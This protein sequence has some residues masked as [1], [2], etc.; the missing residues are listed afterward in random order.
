M[1]RGGRHDLVRSPEAEA[2]EHDVAALGRARREGDLERVGGDD[3]GEPCAKSIPQPHHLLEVRQAAAP[4]EGVPLQ[5][6]A[7]GVERRARHRPKG[8]GVEIRDPLQHGELPPRLLERHPTSR[9]TGAWSDS[10]R[11]FCTRRERSHRGAGPPRASRLRRCASSS[12]TPRIHASVRLR[13]R[14]GAR[15]PG[16]RGEAA[17]VAIPL[18]ACRPPRGSPS[19]TAST[20]SRPGSAALAAGSRRRPSAI[21]RALAKLA[22]PAATSST[23]S[24]SSAPESDSWLLHT[25]SAARLHRPRPAAAANGAPH[26]APGGACSGAST[27]SSRTASTDAAAWRRSASRPRSS[28]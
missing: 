2:L 3:V 17:H 11:P 12:P 5:R 15:A 13:A 7:D 4:L 23:C 28:V 1:L 20:A 6:R 18:R 10:T 14:G 27:G 25:R 21:P 19:T 24:G 16:A 9:S 8:A 26:D 22:T